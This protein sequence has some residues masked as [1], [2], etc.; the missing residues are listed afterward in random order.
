MKINFILTGF[1]RSGGMKIILQ[2][3][4]NLT[5]KGND[6]V[7]YFPV[8]P[9]IF[10]EREK[11]L[12]NLYEKI[13]SNLI[14]V[15]KLLIKYKLP[16]SYIF[17]IKPV[18][19]IN[20]MF[21]RSA[22]IIIATQWPT[23]YSVNK[24]KATKGVKLYLIQGYETWNSDLKR[25][26]D[27][28]KLPLKRI[29][30]SAYLH[31]L[32]KSNFNVD[33]TVIMDG[34]DFDIFKNNN[35]PHKDHILI[36]FIDHYLKLKDVDTVLKAIDLVHLKYPEVDFLCFG[37]EKYSNIPPF[38]KF[39]KNPDESQI[40]NIY[41]MTDIFI[42]SSIEEGYGLPPAEAMACGCAVITTEVGAIPDF[43][44]NNE[45][46]LYFRKS[47]H[48]DL[49]NKISF[50]IENPDI[51][52]TIGEKGS[53]SVRKLLSLEVSFNTFE[54]FLMNSLNTK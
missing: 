17:K 35:I 2:Y 22:D 27:S 50:L 18:P 4:N 9:Y 30:V 37:Y 24:L 10:N 25:V 48:M 19:F 44:I 40:V 14:L 28:Y 13:L 45:T 33:S 23:A 51:M 11:T 31:K 36:T 3:A 12:K 39:I 41:N 8:I 21:I 43:T 32:L 1:F 53:L 20:N 42:F 6:V 15:I 46:A 49:Y 16:Y 7:F 34:L 54:R 29:T 26:E 52:K 5:Q 38:V 47:D